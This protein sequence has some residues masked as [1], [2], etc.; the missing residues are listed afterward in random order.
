VALPTGSAAIQLNASAVN[1]FV[2]VLISPALD[3]LL[4]PSAHNPALWSASE[5]PL[6]YRACEHQQ[7]DL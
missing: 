6:Q 5:D 7:C 2:G 3:Y 1:N 4:V